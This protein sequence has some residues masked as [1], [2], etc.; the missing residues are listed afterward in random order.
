M[1][2]YQQLALRTLA[3]PIAVLARFSTAEIDEITALV[4]R[5]KQLG[6]SFDKFKRRVFYGDKR[7]TPLAACVPTKFT[8]EF[9]TRL[10]GVTINL[11]HSGIGQLTEAAEFLE[12]VFVHVALGEPLDEVN[13]AEEIGDGQWYHAVACHAL[14]TTI[15]V[16]QI[17]NIAKLTARYPEKFDETQAVERDLAKERGILEGKH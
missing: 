11:I 16:V 14:R 9:L 10:D 2:N 12:G 15:E 6:C 4:A 17:A 3:P 7:Q 13:L 8:D 5:A 1:K